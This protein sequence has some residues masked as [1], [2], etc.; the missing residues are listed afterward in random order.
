MDKPFGEVILDFIRDSGFAAITWQ[1]A[2]MLLIS[3]F[4]IYLAIKKKYEP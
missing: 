1:Q 4:L 3:W 2:L